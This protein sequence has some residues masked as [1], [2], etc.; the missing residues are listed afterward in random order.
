MVRQLK[1]KD[2]DKIDDKT[3]FNLILKKARELEIYIKY[4]NRE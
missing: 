4:G 2:F 1:I 3:W